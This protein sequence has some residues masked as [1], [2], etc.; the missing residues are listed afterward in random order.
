[1]S[2]IEEIVEGSVGQES[3]ALSAEV[4]TGVEVDV[5]QRTKKLKK[6]EDCLALLLKIVRSNGESLPYGEVNEDLINGMV[7]EIAG[8]RPLTIS[9]LNDQ[10]ALLEFDLDVVVTSVCRVMQGIQRWEEKEIEICCMA[11]TREHLVAI[12][13]SREEFRM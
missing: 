8:I 1:M 13:K 6:R 5:V 4:E 2:N 11:G 9:I 12:E 3:E 7:K 10:D